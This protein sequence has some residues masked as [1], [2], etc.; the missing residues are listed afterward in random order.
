MSNN[1]LA[2]RRWGNGTRVDSDLARE[3][4]LE[5]A[6]VCYQRQGVHKTTVEDVAKQAKVSRTTVYRYF[7]NRD[8]LLTGV[9][10]EHSFELLEKVQLELDGITNFGEFLVEAMVMLL[11]ESPKA[12]LYDAFMGEG[13][14]TASIVSRLCVTSEQVLSFVLMYVQPRYDYAVEQGQ[15]KE[16][17]TLAVALEWA[18]RMLLSCMTTPSPTTESEHLFRA[19]LKTMLLPAVMK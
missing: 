1:Q 8:E 15:I 2:S 16:G 5:S 19:F 13:G 10:L 17:M 14:D 7:T 6:K 3:Q 12:P 4:I 18:A 9:V 11:N